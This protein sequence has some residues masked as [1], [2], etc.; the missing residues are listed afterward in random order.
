MLKLCKRLG[1]IKL[2]RRDALHV[3]RLVIRGLSLSRGHPNSTILVDGI[4]LTTES[5]ST[6]GGS[7]FFN[8][9][10]NDVQHV[11]V[12]KGP[13]SAFC[14]R[15]PFT[16]AIQYVTN[17]PSEELEGDLDVDIG[18]YGRQNITAGISAPVTDCFGLRLSVIPWLC[19]DR[20]LFSTKVHR[21][22]SAIAKS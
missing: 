12:V 11:E 9:R 22:L 7:I 5:V 10:F 13:Q 4:N 15:A 21:Y 3:R 1:V 16:G 2:G 8:S 17:D 19:K 14:R 18:A 6:A 20:V